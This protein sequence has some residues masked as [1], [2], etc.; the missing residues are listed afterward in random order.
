MLVK[1]GAATDDLTKP[2]GIVYY[3][4]WATGTTT[5]QQLAVVTD[6][7]ATSAIVT[8]LPAANTPYFFGVAAVDAAGNVNPTTV[9]LISGSTAKDTTPPS[10]GGCRAA[11]NPTA[12]GGTLVWDPAIDDTTPAS[13]VT[14]NVYAFDVPVD[15]DTQFSKPD[16]VFT[17]VTQGQITTL[18]PAGNYEIVCRAVD[19]SGNEDQNR[20]TVA[21]Q[22]GYGR[23]WP[24]VFAPGTATAIAAATTVTLN[25]PQAHDNQTADPGIQ[26][27]VYGGTSPGG[28]DITTPIYSQT[29]TTLEALLMATDLLKAFSGFGRR[30]PSP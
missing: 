9:V 17:G 22:H 11:A 23:A 30:A 8:G 13:A 7:G 19:A 26:Y 24:P 4:Y 3:V 16:G 28:E 12:S 10:F 27:V 14:Y 5:A 15:H 2:A 29:G 1:W 21:L 25:W 20:H 6:P 18:L